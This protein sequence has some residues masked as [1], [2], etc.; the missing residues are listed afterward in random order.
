MG[1][2]GKVQLIPFRAKHLGTGRMIDLHQWKVMLDGEMVGS[3]SKHFSSAVQWTSKIPSVVQDYVVEEL[4]ELLGDCTISGKTV[5][6]W[7]HEVET[8][9]DD[10]RGD[11]LD[12]IFN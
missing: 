10:N 12:D 7:D 5:G 1:S 11:Q 6:V 3:K 2:Y 9:E 4:R 8:N